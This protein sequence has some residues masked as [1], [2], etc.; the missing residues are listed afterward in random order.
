MIDCARRR[1][2][3]HN[4]VGA[5]MSVEDEVAAAR[6]AVDDLERA[7]ARVTGHFKE[8]ID[9]RRLRLDVSRLREDI[10]LVCGARPAAIQGQFASAAWDDGMDDVGFSGRAPR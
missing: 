10:D 8:S 1:D 5:G 3:D 4:D 7:T 9:V 2:G 6:A